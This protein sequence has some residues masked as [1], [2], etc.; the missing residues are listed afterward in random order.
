M[1]APKL[2]FKT[3]EIMV[4]HTGKTMKFTCDEVN[5]EGPYLLLTNALDV[6][7]PAGDPT[8]L[9]GMILTEGSVF[10]VR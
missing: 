9:V 8:P 2:E 3:I 7:G 5:V 1:A 4:G 6:M 10:T